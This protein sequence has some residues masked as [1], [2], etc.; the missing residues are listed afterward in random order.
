MRV[1]VELAKNLFHTKQREQAY[2][3]FSHC[4]A[5]VTLGRLEQ[6]GGRRVG[7]SNGG[8]PRTSSL[9]AQLD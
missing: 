2:R 7:T 4:S 1:V 9:S 5:R 8:S 6:D 3:A